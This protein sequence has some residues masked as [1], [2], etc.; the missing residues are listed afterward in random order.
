MK[1]CGRTELT[2]SPA[3]QPTPIGPLRRLN[4][5]AMVGWF[6]GGSHGAICD[7]VHFDDCGSGATA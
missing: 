2:C 5:R 7:C 1:G 3:M 6:D 4:S